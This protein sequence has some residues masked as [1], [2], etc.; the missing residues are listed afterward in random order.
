MLLSPLFQKN[1][2]AV[3]VDEA[4]CVK[5]SLYVGVTEQVHYI[6]YCLLYSRGESF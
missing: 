3:A 5:V 1:L 6:N 4:Y 2:V